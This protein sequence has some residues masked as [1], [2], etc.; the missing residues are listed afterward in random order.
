MLSRPFDLM[1]QDCIEVLN[2]SKFTEEKCVPLAC[3]LACTPEAFDILSGLMVLHF[4]KLPR[5]RKEDR[6][7]HNVDTQFLN[8]GT[9]LSW[10]LES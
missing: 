4:E 1:L 5:R 6:V 10:Q 2:D 3:E 9:I 7:T 8:N